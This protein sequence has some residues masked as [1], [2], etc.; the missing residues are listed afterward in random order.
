MEPQLTGSASTVQMC[1]RGAGRGRQA[2]RGKI[3]ALGSDLFSPVSF[4]DKDFSFL[5]LE[6]Y[7]MEILEVVFVSWRKGFHRGLGW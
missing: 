3:L 4:C 5:F 2:G 1:Q 6:V 7:S